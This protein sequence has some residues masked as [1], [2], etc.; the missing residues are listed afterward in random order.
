MVTHEPVNVEWALVS[1]LQLAE[2]GSNIRERRMGP[3]M[4][5]ALFSSST[6]PTIV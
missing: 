2:G 6:D 3:Y 4:V 1:A 5:A